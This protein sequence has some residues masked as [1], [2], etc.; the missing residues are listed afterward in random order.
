MLQLDGSRGEGGGQVVRSALALAIITGTPFR[1][2]KIRAGRSKGGLL[3]QHLTAVQ[4]AARISNA[5]VSGAQLGSSVLTF[6]PQAAVAGEYHFA[7]GSAGSTTLVLQTVLLPL[8]LAGGRSR[9]TLEGGTH[10]PFAPPFEFLV[11]SYLRLLNR[12]GPQVTARLERPGF[13]PAGGGRLE[14]TIEPGALRGIELLERGALRRR[15]A[16]VLLAH[17]P[18]HI[19]ERELRVLGEQLGLGPEAL[20]LVETPQSIG[21]GNAVLV[22]F[23][24]EQVTE[25]FTALGQVGRPAEA[26]AGAAV[27]A[28]QRY[29]AGAAPVGP[30][31]TD[32]LMLPLALAGAGAFRST[33]M[34]PHAWT[35]LELIGRFL[36]RRS[37]VEPLAGGEVLVAF[38]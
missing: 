21:P 2:E 31:L 33:G 18:R 10:N 9:V 36:E 13:F 12:M 29:A 22:E 35:H 16:K 25:V 23:A 1:M 28:A 6:A 26:V 24:H 38:G 32:Q 15:S 8:V 11:E 34:T 27:D 4:A 7:I 37:R 20:Q 30:Y 5:Q 3:R 19:A 14:V 17:L